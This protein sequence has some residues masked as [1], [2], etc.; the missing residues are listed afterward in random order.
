MSKKKSGDPKPNASHQSSVVSNKPALPASTFLVYA[1]LVLSCFILFLPIFVSYSYYY[2]YIFLKSILFRIAVQAMAFLYVTLA[3][4]SPEYKPRFHRITYALLAWFG[5]MLLCSIPGI[6]SNAWKSWWGDFPRMDGMFTQ[7]HLLAFFFVLIQTFKQERQWL[8]LF[9]ASLFASIVM[10]L[11][12]LIQAKGI[13]LFFRF[14]SLEVRIQGATGNPDFFGSYMLLNLFIALFFLTRN[15]K[16]D[17]YPFIAKVGLLV[18][19]ALDACLLV[20]DSIS[21][22]QIL[23][24]GLQFLPLSLFA[25]ALHGAVL[26]WFFMRRSV[27]TGTVFLGLI[28]IYDLYWLNQSQTRAS[29]GGLAGGLA[30][31]LLM[32]LWKGADRRLKW[33]AALLILLVAVTAIGIFRARSSDWIQ[34]YPL[35]ARLSA[36]SFEEHRFL[37]W[38]LGLSATLDQPILGWGL[39]HYRKAFDLHA[40]AELFQGISG[41]TWDDRAHNM[42][43]DAGITTGLLGLAVMGTFYG[44]LFFLL[45]RGWFRNRGATEYLSIAGLLAAYLVQNLFSFDTINTYGILFFILAY[46]VYL[47]GKTNSGS[48]DASSA[49]ATMGKSPELRDYAILVIAAG[50]LI[51]AW[52]YLVREPRDSNRLLQMGIASGKVPGLQPDTPVYVFRDSVLDDFRSAEEFETTGRYQVREEL[53]NYVIEIV[54]VPDIAL[55]EKARAARQAWH[56]MEKSVLEDPYDARHFMYGAT[57][58]NA[59]FEVIKQSDS[60]EAFRI[61]ERALTWLQK[62][63]RLRPNRPRLYLERTQ[64]LLN[65]GRMEEAIAANRKALSLDPQNKPIHVELVA[66]YILAG[67]NGDAENEWKK[68]KSY[69]GGPSAK[70]YERVADLYA[71]KKQLAPL[72]ALYKEQLQ[73][74]PKNPVVMARLATAYREMG[75]MNAARQTALEAAKISPEVAAQV[76]EFLKTLGG[77]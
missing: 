21:G 3:L 40:P 34:K 42:I 7:L 32:Y 77:K 68:I 44:F 69:P 47:C 12:G 26:F 57:L 23:S 72:I 31:V 13:D 75:D 66:T 8:T 17:F 76:E 36:S 27:W 58:T 16:K 14:N 25:L 51:C 54:R 20:W 45:L 10:G 19:I 52:Y 67:R 6:S 46:A 56:F 35:L 22:G 63:E 71:A 62:A 73:Q 1:I 60:A 15:G 41:E 74:L 64:L 9:T 50:I 24:T 48:Q 29:A 4:I 43:L 18:L 33:A 39:E 59:V 65:L 49:P 30:F 38:K 37:A 55:P 61:S 53:A 70:D 28:C 5:V 2:P 11:T